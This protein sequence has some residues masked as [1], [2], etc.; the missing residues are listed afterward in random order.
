MQRRAGSTVTR[1]PDDLLGLGVHEHIGAVQQCLFAE[2]VE[3][4]GTFG[5]DENL[6]RREA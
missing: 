6:R 1:D 5:R 4:V 2:A 3:L